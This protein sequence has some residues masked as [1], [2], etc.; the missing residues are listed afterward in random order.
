MDKPNRLNTPDF[1]NPFSG[2]YS[3]KKDIKLNAWLLVATVFYAINMVAGKRHPEW[4]PAIR[5][6]LALVPLLPGLL[7]IRSLMRFV[8]GMDELQRRIQL[9]AWLFAAIGTILVGMAISTLN[10]SGVHWDGVENGLG[11][12]QAFLVAFVLWLVAT[13]MANRRYK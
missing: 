3:F 7:Y 12:G 5:A 6:T 1:C 13:A 9:E 2:H 11:M 4:S 10:S 8:R